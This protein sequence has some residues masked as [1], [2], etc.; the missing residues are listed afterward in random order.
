MKL[1]TPLINRALRI[2]YEAHSGQDDKSGVPY[3]FHPTY[4]AFHMDTEDEIITALLHDVVEDTQVTFA[5]LE[6]ENFPYAVL[7]ALRL[8]TRPEDS[9]YLEYIRRMCSNPLAV[10][11]KLADLRHNL[12]P[13]RNKHLSPED[14][15]KHK[16]KYSEAE[17]LL[18]RCLEERKDLLQRAECGDMKAK[19]ELGIEQYYGYTGHSD[20]LKAFE[21]LSCALEEKELD[22]DSKLKATWVI[23]KMLLNDEDC[24]LS[25]RTEPFWFEA[26]PEPFEEMDEITLHIRYIFRYITGRGGVE[27]D[28]E[29]AAD[30]AHYIASLLS[31]GNRDHGASLILRSLLQHAD[32]QESIKD[33]LSLYY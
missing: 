29:K 32:N 20:K 17:L 25:K 3:I 18:E 28:L 31:F 10:K 6:R 21:L 13:E 9:E 4:V 27:R 22:I 33:I 26:P 8:L 7:D 2:A 5:D 1:Y 12:D 23:T 15:I 19:L 16:E 11:V 24:V 14:V 30:A